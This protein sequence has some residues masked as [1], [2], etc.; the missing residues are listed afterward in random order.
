MAGMTT[1]S[2]P[3]A[4]VPVAPIDVQIAEIASCQHGFI[5]LHQLHALGLTT[6]GVMKRL[7]SGRLHRVQP[8]VYAVGHTA[9]S[10]E[11]TIAAVLLSIGPGTF[12][13]GR[14]LAFL[15]GSFPRGRP[16][17]EVT[18][19]RRHRGLQ[20]ATVRFTRSLPAKECTTFRGLASTTTPRMIVDL[21]EHLTAHQVAHAI[22]EARRRG[23]LR[24][25]SLEAAARRHVHRR[26]YGTLIEA[27]RLHRSGSAGTRSFAEDDF[28]RMVLAGDVAMPMV[29]VH[30][31]GR[32]RKFEVDFSW[33]ELMLC[34]EVDGP[35]HD[36]PAQQAKDA[37]RDRQLAACGF[38]VIRVPVA[39]LAAG[40][41]KVIDRIAQLSA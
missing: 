19:T 34:V 28:L 4:A 3:P 23:Q 38:E 9:L 20:D 41:D 39:V 12:V 26:G 10:F 5:H 1:Y 37:E 29:N 35:E 14:C 2:I 33:P 7:R 36:L 31:Q 25:P 40:A 8:R 13:S 24:Y 30:V 22:H 16:F 6:S 27:M 32:R 17:V 21:A 18:S 11:A 15:N